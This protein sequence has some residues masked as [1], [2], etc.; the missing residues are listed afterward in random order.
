MV[1]AIA[2]KMVTGKLPFETNTFDDLS[3]G[4]SQARVESIAFLRPDLFVV[5]ILDKILTKALEPD[6]AKNFD[7]VSEFKDAIQ[8]WIQSVAGELD[9]EDEAPA[10]SPRQPIRKWGKELKITAELLAAQQEAARLKKQQ[11]QGEQ[12]LAAQFTKFVSRGRRKSP[13]RTI[14]ELVFT[15]GGGGLAVIGIIYYSI[16][17]FE[18]LKTTYI[19]ASQRLSAQVKFGSRSKTAVVEATNGEQFDYQQDPS[20]SRWTKAKVVGTA[21]RIEPDG[22]LTEKR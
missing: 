4:E 12:T 8:T 15:I 19:K 20:Y 13:V 3:L 18:S 7:T 10:A 14:L 6:P 17:N 2:F 9:I 1:A 22:K 11:V 21:R 16:V 5:G